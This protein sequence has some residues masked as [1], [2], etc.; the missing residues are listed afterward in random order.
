MTKVFSI[1]RLVISL[2]W[3][4]SGFW[5]TTKGGEQCIYLASLHLVRKEGKT[6][7]SLVAGPASLIIGIA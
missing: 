5:A 1:G 3:A 2:G 7:F 4:R 6:G